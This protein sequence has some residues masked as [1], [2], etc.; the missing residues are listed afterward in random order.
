M[1]SAANA[2]GIKVPE[3]VKKCSNAD[4]TNESLTEQDEKLC[5][6]CK[7]NSWKY[8]CP[9]C[10]IK[11]CS[12]G[13]VKAHKER[14]KCS[15]VRPSST[16]VPIKEFDDAVLRRD[17]R[18]MEETIRVADVSSRKIKHFGSNHTFETNRRSKKRQRNHIASEDG[19]F[20]EADDQRNVRFPYRLKELKKVAQERGVNL[21]LMPKGMSRHTNNK[22]FFNRKEKSLHWTLELQF[23][24]LS[25]TTINWK[26]NNF[27]IGSFSVIKKVLVSRVEDTVKLN[28]IIETNLVTPAQSDSGNKPPEMLQFMRKFE[29]KQLR[30]VCKNEDK[31]SKLQQKYHLVDVN[32]SLRTALDGKTVVEYPTFFVL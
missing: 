23:V 28:S 11:T 8:K 25:D 7:K 6:E 9:A 26:D 29:A 14:V 16:F 24:A 22:T 15:G 5:R 17:L 31:S 13:C 10:Q 18:F 32:E 20:P 3:E 1:A 19:T 4:L 30:A 27:N 21:L 12:L 2:E